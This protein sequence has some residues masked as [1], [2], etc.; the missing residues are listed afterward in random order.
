MAADGSEGGDEDDENDED[1]AG[2]SAMEERR[3]Q[4]LLGKAAPA[5]QRISKRV[6]GCFVLDNGLCS[7]ICKHAWMRPLPDSQLY[8]C[9]VKIW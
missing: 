3:E 9:H 8:I 7:H 5:Q 1:E 4:A 2:P 6:S